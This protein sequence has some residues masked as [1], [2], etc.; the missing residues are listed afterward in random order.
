MT[1]PLLVSGR[2]GFPLGLEPDEASLSVSLYPEAP[3][4]YGSAS[5]PGLGPE[6]KTENINSPLQLLV[7]TETL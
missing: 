5:S 1:E 3:H 2:R 7:S 6:T 4:Q